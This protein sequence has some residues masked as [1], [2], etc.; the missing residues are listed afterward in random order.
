M[1]FED[2]DFLI[3][4]FRKLTDSRQ[5]ELPSMF[6][7]RVRRLTPDLSPFPGKFSFS[8]FP[9][10]K[11]IV[12]CFY[13]L[14]PTE[15]VVV[16]KGNQIGFTTA[17]LETVVLYHIMA[18]PKPQMFVTADQKQAQT[19]VSLKID[20]MIDNAGARRFIFSQS[21]KARGSRN[22]GDTNKAKEY[23]GGFLHVYGSK[24][25]DSFRVMSYQISTADEVDAYKDSLSDEGSVISLVQNRTD[26]YEGKRKRLWG[27]TPLVK[28]TSKIEPLYEDGDQ[29]KYFVPCKFCGT[30]QELVWHGIKESGETYGIVWE[31]DAEYNPIVKTVGYKC[32]HCGG[33]MKNYDKAEIIPKGEWRP[34][35]KSKHPNLKSF[36]LSPLYNPPGMF[37]WESMV[38]AWAECWDLEHNRPKDKEKYRTFRNTKQ[39]LTFEE[40]GT[41]IKYERAVQFRRFGF[42]RK[43][44]PNLMAITDSGSPILIV[45]ASVDVQ[46][47]CL[48]VDVKGYSAKGVVWTLDFFSL[49]GET[50]DFNGVWDALDEYLENTR[51]LGDDGRA[52][53]IAITLVDSGWNTDYVYAFCA[54]HYAGVYAS[55][56]V[57][58]IKAGETFKIFDKGTLD[59]IGLPLAYH[60]NTTKLKDRISNSMGAAVW[61]TNEFQ[62][63]WYPNFPEDF[64]DDYFKMFEAENKVDEYDRK[65][66]KYLRTIWKQKQGIPNHAFDTYAYNLAALEIFA[67]DFCR[68]GLGLPAMDW[69][70]F[71]DAIKDGEFIEP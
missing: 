71:W 48:F 39:G 17:V 25:P 49:D 6:A 40:A 54:R 18:V 5:Y 32:P 24:N 58:Y 65:T 36:H 59:R 41:Q 46:K 52:Y 42:A 9:Y 31:N 37:S 38:K 66:N 56:G 67:N 14:D 11:K 43:R 64:R 70:A 10:F 19:S 3:G 1:A 7:E 33:I 47:Y 45:V 13:P 27:S 30:M 35:A 51:F 4:E 55:K 12:D 16:M 44:V 21:R 57:D 28:Q 23:P 50:A 26:S 60:V 69:T 29:E 62:P 20:K 53:R 34:T 68:R 15:D 2:V 63:P 61:N 22:T 8:R